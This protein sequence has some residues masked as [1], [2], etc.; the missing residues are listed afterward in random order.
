VTTL[1]LLAVLFPVAVY[2]GF[3]GWLNRRP[4]GT[5]VAGPWDFAGILFAAS[6]FLLVGGPA[7][8][9]SLL[10]TD[11]W[12]DL[13]LFGR[14]TAETPAEGWLLV[15]RTLVFG[16]YF[17]LVVVGAAL[18]LRRRQRM[19]AIY[20][21]DPALVEW[22]LG[23][24]FG[25]LRVPFVQCGNV[26]I[27]DPDQ[28]PP[29][30]QNGEVQ[31]AGPVVPIDRLTTLEVEASVGLCHV[32]LLWDPPV[33]LLRREVEAEVRQAVAARPAPGG[34]VGDWLLILSAALFFLL[35]LGAGLI[36]LLR[37]VR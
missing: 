9:S 22:V 2:L 35:M 23:E 7:L 29:A 34:A 24:A 8:L 27:I 30:S 15:G 16:L 18:I 25:R 21:V 26:L 17:L 32:T 3:L 37:E 11:T 5:V 10:G 20:N 31:A 13:W 4:R 19:T 28:E 12:R 33:S 1:L 36:I 6:G 14:K